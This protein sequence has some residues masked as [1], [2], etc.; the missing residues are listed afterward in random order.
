[1]PARSEWIKHWAYEVVKV[2]RLPVPNEIRDPA[3]MI[4]PKLWIRRRIRRL[5]PWLVPRQ[6]PRGCCWHHQVNW[7]HAAAVAVRASSCGADQPCVAISVAVAD[8]RFLTESE[9]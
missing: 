9:H 4:G 6:N 3:C 5:A 7:R 1:M 2:A 8:Y